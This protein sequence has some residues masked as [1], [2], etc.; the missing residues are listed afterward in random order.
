M[1]PKIHNVQF[2]W[3]Q[4]V[5]ILSLF[6]VCPR[7][8]YSFYRVRRGLNTSMGDPRLILSF[9]VAS[10][11]VGFC[12]LVFDC[13][14]L[15]ARAVADMAIWKV[16][17]GKFC[18]YRLWWSQGGGTHVIRYHYDIYIFTFPSVL[19]IFDL[20]THEHTAI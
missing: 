6:N 15:L 13:G 2:L 16:N 17:E 5:P 10:Y 18:Q 14:Y 4:F 11:I 20:Q 9:V 8:N 12:P 19:I 3:A 7:H 1:G